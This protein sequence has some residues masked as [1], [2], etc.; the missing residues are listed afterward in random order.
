MKKKGNLKNYNQITL[1]NYSS[2]KVIMKNWKERNSEENK[3]NKIVKH[4]LV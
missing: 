1:F 4:F 3:K 2:N